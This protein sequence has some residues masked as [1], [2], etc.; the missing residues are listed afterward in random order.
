MICCISSATSILLVLRVR[1]ES[2]INRQYDMRI[3][4]HNMKTRC[5]CCYDVPMLMYDSNVRPYLSFVCTKVVAWFASLGSKSLMS[6][7][8]HVVSLT[9]GVPAGAFGA[10]AN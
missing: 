3:D 9:D 5:G 2:S 10:R 4:M 6:S 8:D 1:M 7:V